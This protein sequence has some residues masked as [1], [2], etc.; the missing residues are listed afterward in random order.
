MVRTLDFIPKSNWV[1]S[2]P[3]KDSKLRLGEEAGGGCMDGF[4]F[5]KLVLALE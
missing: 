5:E 2:K 4:T 3:L 1:N